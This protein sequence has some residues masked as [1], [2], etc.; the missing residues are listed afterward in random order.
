MGRARKIDDDDDD[1]GI[2]VCGRHR[3]PEQFGPPK[4][5]PHQ[6]EAYFKRLQNILDAL[7]IADIG[8]DKRMY[9]QRMLWRPD[10]LHADNPKRFPPGRDDMVIL[11]LRAIAETTN[12]TAALTLP[13]MSAVSNCMH[14]RW[15]DRGLVWLEAMDA[16][17]LLEILQTLRHLGLQDRL[18]DA[19][20]FKLTQILG[21]PFAPPAKKAA[22]K[23]AKPPTV[24]QRTWDEMLALRKADRQRQA[25]KRRAAKLAA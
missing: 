10:R 12:G 3:A 15:T 17:P 11:L 24:S 19:I 9:L 1:D 2:P 18:E 20:R 16:V 7:E 5:E 13:V 8:W 21:S 23:M 4:P 6:V 14:D 22:R 25:K